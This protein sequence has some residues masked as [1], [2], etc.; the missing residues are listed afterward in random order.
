MKCSEISERLNSEH[1]KKRK[2]N[3]SIIYFLIFML[4]IKMKIYHFLLLSQSYFVHC[5]LCQIDITY[6]QFPGAG[7]FS[8]K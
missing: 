4:K 1:E 7:T 2:K 3:K 6:I 5:F 8:D